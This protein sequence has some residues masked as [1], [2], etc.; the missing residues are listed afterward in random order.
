MRTAWLA[1][2]LSSATLGGCAED[3][4]LCDGSD[5]TRL[6]YL[7]IPNGTTDM[8]NFFHESGWPFLRID[9]DCT[10]LARS[11]AS[12]YIDEDEELFFPFIQEYWTLSRAG[13]LDPSREE[14]VLDHLDVAKWSR[15]TTEEINL[16]SEYGCTPTWWEALGNQAY[17]CNSPPSWDRQTL[18]VYRVDERLIYEGHPVASTAL[19][20]AVPKIYDLDEVWAQNILSSERTWKVPWESPLDPTSIG[21]TW[22]TEFWQAWFPYSTL[23]GEDATWF[24]ETRMAYLA[25]A[26]TLYSHGDR[27]YAVDEDRG[28]LISLMIR[29]NF[30]VGTPFEVEEPGGGYYESDQPDPSKWD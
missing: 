24:H 8:P 30:E 9:G 2:M 27:I 1:L 15:V 19:D 23:T 6:E 4:V 10:Y 3:I 17:S 11:L 29:D 22:P 14:W 7:H 18:E 5:G 16:G 21:D 13:Q 28:L 20:V 26:P 12:L 25:K